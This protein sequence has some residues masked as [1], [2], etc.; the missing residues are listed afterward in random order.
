MHHNTYYV[1]IH[2]HSDNQQ[3][4]FI[5]TTKFTLNNIYVYYQF[6]THIPC[7]LT[8]TLVP[9]INILQ[10]HAHYMFSIANS[11]FITTKFIKKKKKKIQH[12]NNLLHYIT[13]HEGLIIKLN[14]QNLQYNIVQLRISTTKPSNRAIIFNLN[15]H[16]FNFFLMHS[17][18]TCT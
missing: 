11:T 12:Y 14:S 10:S 5:N 8:H 15:T 6:C 7:L 3:C 18:C 16:I 13:R 17:I 9:Y 1:H 4:R 2:S